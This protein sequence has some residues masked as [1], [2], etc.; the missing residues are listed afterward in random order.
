MKIIHFILLF[1]FLTGS[2]YSLDSVFFGL[3]G[4]VNANAREGIA[5]GGTLSIG[6]DINRYF[7]AGVKK[8]YSVDFK[9]ITTIEDAVFFR[10]YPLPKLRVFIQ[11][12]LGTYVLYEEGNTQPTLL[13]AF[14]A[15]VR[16]PIGSYFYIEPQVRGGYPFIWG[17]GLIAGINFS[18]K[19]NEEELEV[20]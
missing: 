1:V 8:T 9:D 5:A 20:R 16:I 17:G 10:F 13:G 19:K 18:G 2:V 11:A 7:S 14:V 15:G 6:V 4:E 3:G 12:E